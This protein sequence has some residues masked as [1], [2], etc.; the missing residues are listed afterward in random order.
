MKLFSLGVLAT[1][2]GLAVGFCLLVLGGRNLIQLIFGLVYKRIMTEHYWTNLFETYNLAKMI[3]LGRL[4]E[5]ELRSAHGQ[6]P[7]RPF[8]LRDVVSPWK[9]LYFNPVYLH[10]LPLLDYTKV[11]TE[12]VIGPQAR[13]PL[14][15]KIPILNG[16]MAYGTALS[17]KTKQ[18][19][20]LGATM[21]GTAANTGNGPFL[22]A[23][24]TAAEKLIV[25]YSRGSWAK[26]LE[27]LQAANAIEIQLG[28]GLWGPAPVEIPATRLARNPKL[29]RLL[30]VQPGET[31]KIPPRFLEVETDQELRELVAELREKTGG[32]PIGIKLGATQWLE[33]ELEIILRANPDFVAI[34]GIEGGTHGNLGSTLDALGLPTLYALVRA[35]QF[36]EK[37]RLSGKV[38][39][40][41]GGGLYSSM[42]F[43]KALALGAD[44]VFI[45]IIALLAL[46]HTQA[47]KVL[48]WEPP[49]TLIYNR[50]RVKQKFNIDQG[51]QALA[52]FFK[53][54]VQE[55]QIATLTLGKNHLN[56][57][58]KKDLSSVNRELANYLGVKWCGDPAV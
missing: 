22:P 25:Q 12:V 18:A 34:D 40:L 49:T 27:T 45:G 31:A 51:A 24:R 41:V 14:K 46:V 28:Q 38:S 1:V 50:G 37:K 3:G 53:A 16:G 11:G 58:D 10:R 13:Y 23:E 19:L 42:D 57:V 4:V 17:A 20:A 43:L 8:G 21:A 29:R 56:T 6:P 32:I 26:D 2:T 30:G 52:N 48:P 54:S 47:I 9:E 7:A 39:L 15:L 5:T 36:L 55:M 35:R 33:R 44:A